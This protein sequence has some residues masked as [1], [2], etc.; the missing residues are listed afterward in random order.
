MVLISKLILSLT[1]VMRLMNRFHSGRDRNIVAV[2][3]IPVSNKIVATWTPNTFLQ[4]IE[5]FQLNIVYFYWSKIGVYFFVYE[6]QKIYT[7]II[8]Q[9]VG[10]LHLYVKLILIIIDHQIASSTDA[11]FYLQASVMLHHYK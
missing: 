5:F 7:R 4:S 2:N 8:I 9:L 1:I 3:S 11:D 10:L 6:F